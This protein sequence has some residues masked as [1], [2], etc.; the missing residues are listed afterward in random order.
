MH[1]TQ[2]DSKTTRTE[3]HRPNTTDIEHQEKTKQIIIGSQEK[4]STPNWLA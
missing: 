4:S 3:T 1:I 2:Q